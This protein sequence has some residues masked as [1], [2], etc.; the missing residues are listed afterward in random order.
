MIVEQPSD[1]K[2]EDSMSINPSSTIESKSKHG[3]SAENCKQITVADVLCAACKQLLFRPVALN[4]GHG[5]LS[6]IGFFLVCYM[7]SGLL[8]DMI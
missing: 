5:M 3:S 2:S 8:F 4:C 6:L 1:I 7:F